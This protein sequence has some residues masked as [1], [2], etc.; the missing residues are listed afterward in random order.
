MSACIHFSHLS[1]AYS[2]Q[3]SLALDNVDFAIGKGESFA[4]LG[5]N[6][7][8]K[9]TLLRILCGRLSALNGCV[10]L[11]SEMRLPN[12]MLNL[13]KCGI[14]LENPGVYP[15]LSIEEYLRFFADFYAVPDLKTR[16]SKLADALGILNLFQKMGTLS[17]GMRQKV[18]IMR[19]LLPCPSLLLLDEPVANLDPESRE[20][21]WEL[22]ADWKRQTNGTLVVCSHILAEMDKV[23]TS[24]AILERG[25]LLCC[26]KVS[27][28]QN[29]E[30]EIR[31]RIPEGETEAAFCEHLL[32]SAK[33]TMGEVLNVKTVRPSLEK[34]YWECVASL[35]SQGLKK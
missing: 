9:T 20:T 2:K 33:K 12:G 8:G 7:A 13:A 34:L 18:Q 29:R 35:K 4:L 21:V 10:K 27:D 26:K 31:V 17:Q 11:D 22:L 16:L 15:R 32:S 3:S 25:K 28:L 24:F 14:L 30:V 19:A 23:A 6:G 5:P 1:F